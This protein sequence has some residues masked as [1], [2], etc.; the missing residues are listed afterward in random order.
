MRM[1]LMERYIFRRVA[2]AFFLALIVL[3]GTLWMTQVL[4]QLD[5]VTAK[6][7]TVWVFLF[8]TFL[9]MPELIQIIAPVAFLIAVIFVLNSLIS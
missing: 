3:V 8:V 1:P 7:Q 5:V 2:S 6:G 4:K 9:A